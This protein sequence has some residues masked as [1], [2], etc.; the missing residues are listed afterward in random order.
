MSENN[1]FGILSGQALQCSFWQFGKGLIGRSKNRQCFCAFQ[2]VNQSKVGN[3]FHQG[4]EGSSIDSNI[5]DILRSCSFFYRSWGRQNDVINDMDDSI[6]GH[7]ISSDNIN[8]VTAIH[9]LDSSILG[10]D[11]IDDF[12]ANGL[13][14]SSSDSSSGY[15][16]SDDMPEYNFFSGLGGQTFQCSF[17]QFGKGLIRWSKDRQ[18]FRAFQCIDQSK[19]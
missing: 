1:C 17:W 14:R 10:L 9:D 6:A 11:Q 15:L 2:R 16:G 19:I 4:G 5:D 13:N 7:D 8:S 12:T 3:N 18:S